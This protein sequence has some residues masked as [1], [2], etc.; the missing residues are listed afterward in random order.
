MNIGRDNKI[1]LCIVFL[2]LLIILGVRAGSADEA[3]FD[4]LNANGPETIHHCLP[5][6]QSLLSQGHCDIFGSKNQL[7]WK[8]FSL[9][10]EGL[11]YRA[12]LSVV[13]K[14]LAPCFKI[15]EQPVWLVNCKLLL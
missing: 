2:T 8:L 5:G 14:I 4:R 7:K 10:G 1:T 6:V 13:S 9:I 3:G 11:R 12:Q 15:A